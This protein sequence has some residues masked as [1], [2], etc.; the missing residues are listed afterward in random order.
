MIIDCHTH[1]AKYPDHYSEEHLADYHR[2]WKGK[3]GGPLDKTPQDHLRAMEAVDKAV[4][5]GLRARDSGYNVPND[6]VAAY[7]R[8]NPEKLIGFGS[9]DPNYDDAIKEI[10][11]CTKALGLRGLKLGPI[12]QH[13]DPS[14][15]K[16]YPIW[17]AAQEMGLPI[18]IH[19]GTTYVR[20]APLKYALPVLLEDIALAFPD[21]TV[22]IAHMGHP[23]EADTIALIRKQPNFYAD[24]SAL[25]PRPYRLYNDLV[26]A[27]EYGVLHKLVFGSDYPVLTPLETMKE[28]RRVNRFAEGT[29]L[30]RVP[31]EAIEAIISKNAEVALAPLLA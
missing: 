31:K 4:V 25:T 11:R 20:N 24:V 8:K 29:N 15:K 16:Y 6:Y 22:I 13:F 19:Q 2:A 30:P 18:V 21:L 28:L 12:Y 17:E 7:A 3:G 14:D 26:L 23:W 9:I 5:F 10:R 1:V 27:T